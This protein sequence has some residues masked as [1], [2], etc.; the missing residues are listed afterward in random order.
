MSALV[1]E[2]DAAACQ[3]VGGYLEGDPV[4][5]EHANAEPAHLAGD[6]R[7][8]FVSV[9]DQHAEGRVRKHLGY[10]SFELDCFFFRHKTPF[11]DVL[12]GVKKTGPLR[13]EPEWPRSCHTLV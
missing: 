6:G 11:S 8:D 12:D 13:F 7:V 2:R 9:R 10:S 3:V 4:A 5:C 1:P